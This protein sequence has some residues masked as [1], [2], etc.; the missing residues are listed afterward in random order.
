[1]NQKGRQARCNGSGCTDSDGGN[2]EV[3]IIFLIFLRF[4]PADVAKRAT[5]RPPG[6]RSHP[7]RPRPPRKERLWALPGTLP[8]LDSAPHG[9]TRSDFATIALLWRGDGALRSMV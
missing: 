7:Q 1:M 9:R 5:S 8:C 3:S 6:G 4:E 2:R